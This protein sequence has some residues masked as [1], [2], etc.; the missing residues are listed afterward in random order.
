[1]TSTLGV[2]TGLETVVGFDPGDGQVLWTVPRARGPLV[3]PAV[4]EG[5]PGGGTIVYEEGAGTASTI[6]AIGVTDRERRWAVEVH[7]ASLGAPVVADGRVYVGARDRSIYAIDLASGRIDWRTTT[8]GNVDASAAVGD[9]HVFV[10]SEDTDTGAA[11]LYALD[12]ATGRTRWSFGPSRFAAHVSSPTVIPGTVFV[13][14]GDLTV[15]AFDTTRGTVRWAQPVR[16]DFGAQSSPAFSNG[17][18]FIVD[19]EGALYRFDAKTGE[20]IWE[21]QFSSLITTSGPLVTPS[22]VFEGLDDGSIAAVSVRS[23]HLLFSS[24]HHVGRI[25]PLSPIGDL[26]LAPVIAPR[27]GLVAFRHDPNGTL[28]DVASPSHV[29]ITAGLSNFGLSAALLLIFVSVLFRRVL[30]RP[31]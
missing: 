9:G 10:V 23:G 14:F 28:V 27:G 31:R 18:L 4:D 26:L 16:G 19:R 1:M 3:P 11:R 5:G 15:R 17:S 25:G 24:P 13:G 20:R 6:V 30:A 29:N 21:Y 12:P 22:T 7:A 2:A 8:A